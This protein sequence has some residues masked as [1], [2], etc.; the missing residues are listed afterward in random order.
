MKTMNNL[1]PFVSIF[2]LVVESRFKS[3]LLLE[4]INTFHWYKYSI[5]VFLFILSESW[6][7]ESIYDCEINY[8]KIMEIT[9]KLF[10]YQ[11]MFIINHVEITTYHRDMYNKHKCIW[12]CIHFKILY[13][14]KAIFSITYIFYINKQKTT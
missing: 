8:Y 5:W 14:F 13:I 9:F 1:S 7:T 2:R 3:L 12:L 6:P 11:I 10:S 4:F